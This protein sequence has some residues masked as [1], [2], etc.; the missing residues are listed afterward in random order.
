MP[1]EL[2][3]AALLLLS[4]APACAPKPRLPRRRPPLPPR[5]PLLRIQQQPAP[6]I[7]KESRLVL[8]DAIVTD[9]K[10]AYVHDLT[11]KDFKV[12]EDNKEQQVASFSSGADI[13]I[14]AAN[15]QKRYLI[16]FF[17]NSSMAAPDQIQARGAAAK[18]VAATPAPI[19]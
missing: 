13:A 7:K 11:Q 3:P 4:C 18:F 9:K 6:V 16:L 5:L 1:P 15:P 8:V 12:Y 10:G 17:D 19:A 2:H 14:Q